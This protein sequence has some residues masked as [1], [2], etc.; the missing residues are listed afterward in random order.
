M[1][2]PAAA[3]THPPTY[4]VGIQGGPFA[5]ADALRTHARLVEALGYRELFTADHFGLP[6]TTGSG[7]MAIDPFLPLLIATEA[8]TGLRVGPLVL[9]NEF[10]NPA[11][12]ARTVATADRLTGG[13]LVLGV[14]TGYAEAE[15]DAIGSPIRPPGPRVSRLSES[16]EVLR[17]LLDTGTLA[18]EGDHESIK[19]EDLGVAPLQ[20]PVPFLIGGFGRRVVKLAAKHA[21]IFQFTGLTHGPDGTP[22][23]GGFSLVQVA[24]RGEWL[25]E[26]AGERYSQIELSALVQLTA[27]GGDTPS[28]DELSSRFG[29]NGAELD[30]SPFV[31]VGSVEQVVD[32]IERLREVIG[33]THYVVRDPEGFAPVLDALSKA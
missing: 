29:L 9:N 5:S 26:A 27:I 33:V 14:G 28:V 15:H 21:D 22:S 3:D 32:K 19:V 12:L 23:A 1:S 2:H 7:M 17:A 18:F 31:M 20:R 4:A 25:R 24:T 10:Y 16:L 6:G 11:L 13:R 30:D 8:T